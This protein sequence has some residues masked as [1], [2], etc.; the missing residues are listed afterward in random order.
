MQYKNRYTD[1]VKQNAYMNACDCL[2]FGFGKIFWN[3]CGCNDD[4]VWDQA[5]R[6][7]GCIYSNL[8]KRCCVFTEYENRKTILLY[9]TMLQR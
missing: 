7:M 3:D 4:S 6:D 9:F 2:Y 5:M 1:K 8:R